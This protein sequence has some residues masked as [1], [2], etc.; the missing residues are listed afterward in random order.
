MNSVIEEQKDIFGNDPYPYNLKENKKTLEA[1]I[2]Y[3]YE[4]GLTRKKMP[5]EKLFAENT[6]DY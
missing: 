2:E 6:L 4:Q 3:S 1:I 5:T